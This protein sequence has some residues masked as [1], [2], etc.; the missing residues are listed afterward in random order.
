MAITKAGD[1]LYVVTM[2]RNS[3]TEINT[4]TNRRV[5]EFKVEQL[6]FE[7]RLSQDEQSLIVTNWGGRPMK[8]DDD[9]AGTGNTMIVVNEHGAAA[10]GSVS[11]VNRKSGE[12]ETIPVG[13]HPTGIALQG[14]TAYI[15]NA[16]SDSI[17][18]LDIENR[19]QIK[20][21]QIGRA[22]V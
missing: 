15:A 11:V 16:A 4:R 17:S 8:D 3:V 14:E 19:K 7:V 12:K 18:V 2:D 22:H 13:E 9:F 10:S 5:R 1:L 6:P 21:L 20:T